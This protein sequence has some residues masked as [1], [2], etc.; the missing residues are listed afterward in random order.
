MCYS[1]VHAAQHRCKELR[2]KNRKSIDS[3][4]FLGDEKRPEE[5]IE[6][7]DTGVTRE[8]F[9]QAFRTFFKESF[10]KTD[11]AQNLL[12]QLTPEQMDGF[13]TIA[14]SY[15]RERVGTPTTKTKRELLD[16]YRHCEKLMKGTEKRINELRDYA[17]QFLITGRSR[18]APVARHI[19]AHVERLDSDLYDIRHSVDLHKRR[20]PKF[21]VK[22]LTHE[23]VMELETFIENEFSTLDRKNRDILI[24]AALAGARVFTQ[25]ELMGGDDLLGRIPMKVSRAKEHH[26]EAFIDNQP[27]SGDI[28]PAGRVFPVLTARKKKQKPVAGKGKSGLEISFITQ[29]ILH[30]LLQLHYLIIVYSYK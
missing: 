7:A 18:T 27:Q 17:Q 16:D 4:F 24:A 29:S 5:Y 19:I 3:A 13:F 12:R 28:D 8:S 23:Y 11:P 21:L 2:M 26:R 15:L 20:V 10:D 22:A 9:E 1:L 6:G 30:F 25:K 14:D